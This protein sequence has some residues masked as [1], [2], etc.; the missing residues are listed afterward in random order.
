MRIY[1]AHPY[2]GDEKRNRERAKDAEELLHK[3]TPWVFFIILLGM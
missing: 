3:A 2:T 1:I